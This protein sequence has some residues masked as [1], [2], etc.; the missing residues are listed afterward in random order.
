MSE[1]FVF[2]EL[3]LNPNRSKDIFFSSIRRQDRNRPQ[4][5]IL[6]KKIRGEKEEALWR[7]SNQN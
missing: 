4:G 5:L 7:V 6:E 3:I 1:E 2:S